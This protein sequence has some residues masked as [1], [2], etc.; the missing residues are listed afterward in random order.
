MLFAKA[1]VMAELVTLIFQGVEGFILDLPPG[2]GTTY[3]LIDIIYGYI[4]VGNPAKT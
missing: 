2:A 1:K 4:Q 3:E